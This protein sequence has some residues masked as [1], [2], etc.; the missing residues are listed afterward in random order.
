MRLFVAFSMLFLTGCAP[1][2]SSV[3]PSEAAG[4]GPAYSLPKG[5][6]PI[7]VFADPKGIGLTIEPS[8]TVADPDVGPLVARLSVSPLNNSDIKITVDPQTGFLKAVSSD[9]EAKLAAI[10]EEVGKTAGRLALQ[11]GRATV[12]SEK[13]IVLDDAFDPLDSADVQRINN[14]LVDAFYR[15]GAAFVTASGKRLSPSHVS[16]SIEGTAG[17]AMAQPPD[18]SMCRV[19]VCTRVMTSRVIHVWADGKSLASKV[20][21]VPAP[22]LVALPLPTTVLANQEVSVVISDG[23]L[24]KYDIKRDSEVLGLVK[25][26]GAAIGGIIAGLTQQF[27]DRKSLADKQKEMAESEKALAEAKEAASK[28]PSTIGETSLSLQNAQDSTAAKLAYYAATLTI[29]PHSESLAGLIEERIKNPVKPPGPQKGDND[30]TSPAVAPAPAP[31]K[32]GN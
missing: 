29:Y 32:S 17:V 19:G 20:V 23:M 18:V 28:S 27:E 26:P 6:V 16:I 15:A 2:L 3:G 31:Q 7:Q 5:L 13:V 11:N 1:V 8:K 9:T 25:L 14:D 12:L 30:L 4:G 24:E 22:D 21:H 10:A